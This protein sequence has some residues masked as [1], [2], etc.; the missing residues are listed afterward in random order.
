MILMG[1]IG[2]GELL[3]VHHTLPYLSLFP[4][5]LEGFRALSGREQTILGI[6]TYEIFFSGFWSGM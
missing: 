3:P 4:S 2:T 1:I 6:Y 5:W